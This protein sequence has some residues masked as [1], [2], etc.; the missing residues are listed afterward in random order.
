MLF[1]EYETYFEELKRD[2]DADEIT[3]ETYLPFRTSEVRTTTFRSP[4]S[5]D[6]LSELSDEELLDC[7]N[8]WQ[9][10]H[11]DRGDWSIKVNISA[12]AG[13]F[14]SVFTESIIPDDDR[15][16]FW[17]EK[18][19]E[20]IERPIYVRHMIQAMRRQVEEGN[21]EQYGPMV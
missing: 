14:Q 19:R 11:Y 2:D 7:I 20:R 15:L 13:A 5:S 16:A 21:F 17:I 4:K 1:G 12:L 18:N 9:D 3:D 6:E 8:E 10:E